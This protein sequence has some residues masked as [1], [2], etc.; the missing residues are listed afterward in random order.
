MIAAIILF[1]LV[2]AALPVVADACSCVVPPGSEKSHVTREFNESHAVFLGYV[3]AEHVRV[4]ADNPNYS[5]EQKARR[6]QMGVERERFVRVHVLQV[7]KGDLEVGAWI[8]M[9]ADDGGGSGCGHAAA[10]HTAYIVFS[11]P[12]DVYA[13]SS[14]SNSGR[15]DVQSHLITLLNR[16][17]RRSRRGPP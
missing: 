17:S 10:V 8:D 16:L 5:D 1:A 13:M 14:C 9:L 7:W 3:H 6:I 15:V 12:E 4:V 2:G 11:Y